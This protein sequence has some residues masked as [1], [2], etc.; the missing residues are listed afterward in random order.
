MY[1]YRV[2]FRD[3]NQKL[4]C[5]KGMYELISYLC[6]ELKYEQDDFYKIEEI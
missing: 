3:G 4:F 2:Y 1:D 6:F 5:A